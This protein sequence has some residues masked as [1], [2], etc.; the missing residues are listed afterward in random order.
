MIA[1]RG[2]RRD[3]DDWAAPG[4]PEWSFAEVLPYFRKL[5]ASWR[6]ASE[7]HGDDGPV[8]ISRMQG[9]DLLWSRCWRRPRPRASPTATIRTRPSRTAS[10]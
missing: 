10:R 1:V 6:G 2:N 3:F 9:A 4:L 5:E 8:R 7:W